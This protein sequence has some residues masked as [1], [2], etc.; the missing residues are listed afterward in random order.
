MSRNIYEELSIERKQMQKEGK[1]PEWFTTGGWQMFKETYQY[2]ADGYLE[3]I[4]RVAACMASHAPTFLP[5]S[6]PYYERIT[7]NYGNSWEEVFYNIMAVGHLSPSSPVLSNGGTERGCAVSCSGQVVGDS[8]NGFFGSRHE[9]ALLTKEGFGTSAYLGGIRPRGS[10]ISKG[11]KAEGSLPVLVGFSRDARDVSQAGVRRGSWAGYLEV[12]HGDFDE[13]ADHLHKNPQGLNVGWVFTKEF[14]QRCEDGDEE[15]IRR[16]QKVLWIKMM[17]GKG[18]IWKVDHVAD[19]QPAIYKDRGLRNKASNLCIE[20]TLHADDYHTYT[21]VLSSQN[22][23]YFDVWQNTGATFVSTVF[24]DCVAQDF[25]ERGKNIKGLEKAVRYTQK[26]RSLGLGTLGFHSYLQKNSI[27]FESFEAH[28]KNTLIFKHIHDE[29][30]EASQWMAQVWGE[31]EWCL[32]YGVRGTHNTAIAPNMSSAVMAGQVSQGIEPLFANI[33][34]QPTSVGE[35]QRIN[36]EF[37]KIMQE[38]G[39]YSK[40]VL[41]TIIDNNGSVQ[42][43]TW[44]SDHEKDVFKTAFEID[45]RAILRLAST[46]QKYICQGQSLNLFFDADEKE[47]YIAQ[48]HKEALLDKNIKGLYYIRTLAGVQAAKD[49]CVACEG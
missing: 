39:K 16:F 24:L 41:R 28:Q 27:P 42:H 47:E 38:R 36:P 12:D 43:L 26:A 7:E 8:I 25:I 46:R 13:W 44:L 32:G 31:P 48:I 20:I 17:T 9:S 35:M 3:Q 21:C 11:G 34:S 1:L 4:S 19:Q 5:K 10:T 6:H 45:Q 23:L 22:L 14:I 30:L 40:A 37:L 29:A 18:Y 49:S 15:A 33:F 2:Q